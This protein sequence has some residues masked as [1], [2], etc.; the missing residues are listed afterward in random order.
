MAQWIRIHL[1]TQGTQVWALVWEDSVRGATSHTWLPGLVLQSLRPEHQAV[2]RNKR[3][4][5]R[6]SL[7]TAIK[8]SR[9]TDLKGRRKP[10]RPVQPTRKEKQTL[11][12]YL[13]LMRTWS[14][15]LLF[16]FHKK[17]NILRLSRV[18]NLPNYPFSIWP[19][20]ITEAH[21]IHI[22]TSRSSLHFISASV[23]V[24][25]I[26]LPFFSC[27]KVFSLGTDQVPLLH[28]NLG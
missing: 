24:Y 21:I 1:L 8:R 6:R 25:S 15:V 28:M 19:V 2:L 3:N 13:L 23:P 27:L 5:T 16:Y 14:N 22:G 20:S 12:P 7:S 18:F 9:H 10:P 4:A 17:M 26:L 11:S